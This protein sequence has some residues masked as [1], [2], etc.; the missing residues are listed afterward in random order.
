MEQPL[1]SSS[2]SLAMPPT[3]DAA[4]APA[5]G[6]AQPAAPAPISFQDQQTL[7][8][9]RRGN[10]SAMEQLVSRYQD[11]LYVTILRMVNHPED[12]ADLVQETFVRAMQAV[13]RFEG[14]STLYTWLFRIAV[15]LAISHRRAS[16]YRAAASLDAGSEEEDAGSGV[17]RQA[18]GLRRQLAQDTED[19][20][21]ERVERQMEYERLQ[22]ALARLDPEFK[23]VI[24]LR[25]IEECDYDQIAAI[26]D[27]PVGTVKSRLFRAR[28][29]LREALKS[30][31]NQASA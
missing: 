25:D 28:C 14:K 11:R 4:T 30:P 12:A 31:S 13:A 22:G 6:A 18:A 24:V 5:S 7:A 16:Q 3:G 27:V 23:A 15:N 10:W 1:A 20:P 21:A 29:A 19:D 9:L 26:L 17:N 2:G 8:Q